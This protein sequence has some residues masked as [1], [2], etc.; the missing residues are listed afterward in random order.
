M[1]L[2]ISA[3][4]ALALAVFLLAA[5][6][7]R[8]TSGTAASSTAAKT[9]AAKA[10]APNATVQNATAQNAAAQQSQPIGAQVPPAVPDDG[11]ARIK[12]D[13][14]QAAMQK[15][16]VVLYDVRDKVAYDAGHIKGAKNVP[17][18]EV[19]TRLSEFPKDKQI[20]TYC[21]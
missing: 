4:S 8:D 18:N 10:A 7:P 2:L 14:L 20:V 17:W 19:E 13:E 9:N 21:A 1:R 15:G 16:T 6:S 5:C 3:A 12:Q 11:V